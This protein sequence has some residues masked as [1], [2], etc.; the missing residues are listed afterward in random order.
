M[1]LLTQHRKQQLAAKQKT[2]T[3]V[4]LLNSE[5]HLQSLHGHSQTQE[6]KMMMRVSKIVI[7][8]HNHH[9]WAIKEL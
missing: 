7:I 5:Y 4:S 3:F 9:D 1:S 2:A 8:I 6:Y